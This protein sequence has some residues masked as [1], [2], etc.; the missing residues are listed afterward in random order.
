MGNRG[1]HTSFEKFRRTLGGGV[2]TPIIHGK[3]LKSEN[4]RREKWDQWEAFERGEG[5]IPPLSVQI[6]YSRIRLPAQS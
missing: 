1:S 3:F 5:V 2:T 4:F 6:E